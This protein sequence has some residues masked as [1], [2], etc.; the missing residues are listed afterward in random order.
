VSDNRE[1]IEAAIQRFAAA[2]ARLDSLTVKIG[3][4]VRSVEEGE[5]SLGMLIKEKKLHQDAEATLKSLNDLIADI[6]AHPERYI[7]IE[8][9]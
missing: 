6:K 3:G 5:G 4:I 1:E 2:A 8:I 9:F 7:R